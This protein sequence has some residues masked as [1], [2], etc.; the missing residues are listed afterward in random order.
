M[1]GRVIVV[2]SVNVD[3]VVTGERLPV[4]GET[5]TG[6]TFSRHHG[7][8]GANQAVAA[9]RLGASTVFLGAVGDDDLGVDARAALELEG[10][11]VGFVERVGAPTGVALILVGGGGE[12]LISVASG[13]NA[14]VRPE[15]VRATFERLALNAEDVILVSNEI[16]AEAVDAA[17]S[18]ALAAGART[19]LNPAPAQGIAA[20]ALEAT[21]VA[22][23][24]R[25]ELGVLARALGSGPSEHPADGASRLLEAGGVR[26]AVVVTLGAAGALL[27]DRSGAVAVPAPVV[28]AVDT[29][30]AGDAFN[31]CLAA[32]LA[33]GLGLEAAVRRA[34]LAGALATTR[35]GARA[36]MPTAV[37]LDAAVA[38]EST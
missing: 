12:N 37:E 26:D 23:P 38:V 22:T 20:A 10:I 6:G 27:V 29:T 13:A 34:V 9:A 16:S 18:G 5:V 2:G 31:G 32:S 28:D 24:N 8:K 1:P 36:G 30:G 19:V 25:G 7:G 11:D 21:S 4:P 33:N 35:P 15:A 3:F 14:A 17:L